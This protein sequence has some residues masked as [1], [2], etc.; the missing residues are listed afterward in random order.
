MPLALAGP[1]ARQLEVRVFRVT[2]DSGGAAKRVALM[3]EI[4]ARQPQEWTSAPPLQANQAQR[5]AER[6]ADLHAVNLELSQCTSLDELCRRAVELG[7][8]RLNFERI[9]IFLIDPQQPYTMRGAFGTAEDG[10]TTTDDHT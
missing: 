7:R 10:M 1:M 4:A 8:S 2:D 5:F 3:S 9:A 6:L